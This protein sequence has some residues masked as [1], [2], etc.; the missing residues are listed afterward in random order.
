MLRRNHNGVYS[1][2]Y[3]DATFIVPVF[4]RNLRLSVGTDPVQ[5]TVLAHLR[6]PGA[7]FGSQ[8][9]AQRHEFRSLLA[10]IPKHYTAVPRPDILD[11][12]GVDTLRNV[13]TLLLQCHDDVARFVI[14]SLSGIVVSRI[15]NRVANDLLVVDGGRGGDLAQDDDHSCFAYGFASDARRR[16]ESEARV[17]DGVGND[18]AQFVR[19]RFGDGFGCEE[20]GGGGIVFQGGG[21]RGT[22]GG[23]CGFVG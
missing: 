15:A 21:G 23:G 14:Q 16:V 6:E 19:V 18:I 4:Q 20:E 5:R 9:V 22:S 2:G 10:R 3:G 12:G 1:L 11:F 8:N 7:Q 13:R 17:D